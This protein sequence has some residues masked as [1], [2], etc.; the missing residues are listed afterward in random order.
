MS[1]YDDNAFADSSAAVSEFE[2]LPAPQKASHVST[3][4][5]SSLLP[6]Y[7]V[8][9]KCMIGSGL[10]LLAY[11]V[12]DSGWVLGIL[13]C[14]IAAAATYLS[15]HL[16][17]VVA[18]N[19]KRLDSASNQPLSFLRI[20]STLSPRMRP[21][22]DVAI[23]LKCLGAGSAYL[24]FVADLGF[25]LYKEVVYSSSAS[26]GSTAPPTLMDSYLFASVVM[27][28]VVGC[29]AY[30]CFQKAI[31]NTKIFNLVGLLAMM[32]VVLLAIA[33]VDW[34]P[35]LTQMWPSNTNKVIDK[36]PT[37]I[38]AF[39]CHQNLFGV[40][41][42][43]ANPTVKR[44]SL[45]SGLATLTGFVLFMICIIFPYGSFGKDVKENFLKNYLNSDDKQMDYPAFVGCV[46]ACIAVAISFPLQMLPMRRSMTALLYGTKGVPEQDEKR[47]RMMVSG[48]VQLAT[49][50]I[51]LLATKFFKKA[52][53]QVMSITGLIGGNMLCFVFPAW[54]Y[55]CAVKQGLIP[56]AASSRPL[57]VAACG[58]LAGSLALYPLCFLAKLQVF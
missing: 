52:L 54:L 22:V 45:I 18:I 36:L 21:V 24:I 12:C 19:F 48:A 1:K 57:Y 13:S 40:I 35:E 6:G 44:V 9:A 26:S 7:S 46:A 25:D 33:Y 43:L 14:V 11:T 31:S 23:A 27:L 15:L 38:F 41:D 42:D 49:L 50:G 2:G 32:Y 39:T 56:P 20:C 28:G 34:Q 29:F 51:A 53:S 8:L 10:L 17:A 4:L 58:L 37:F 47:V 30:L 55:I 3:G 16:L 5:N